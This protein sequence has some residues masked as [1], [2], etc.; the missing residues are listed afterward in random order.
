MAQRESGGFR[1]GSQVTSALADPEG[2]QAGGRGRVTSIDGEGRLT[3]QWEDNTISSHGPN[4]LGRPAAPAGAAEPARGV[5]FTAGGRTLTITGKH[6][7]TR[8]R[9][10]DENGRQVTMADDKVRAALRNGAPVGGAAARR[11]ERE[12]EQIEARFLRV[13]DI[14]ID[15][16]GEHEV[17]NI[18][19]DPRYSTMGVTMH[20]EEA[21]GEFVYR[22]DARLTVVKRS[23]S[24]ARG[25]PTIGEARE[26]SP[27]EPG[28]YTTATPEQLANPRIRAALRA[29]QRSRR[30]QYDQSDLESQLGPNGETLDALLRGAPLEI[31]QD[32]STPTGGYVTVRVPGYRTTD[33]ETAPVMY[34]VALGGNAAPVR[35]TTT[36][37][38]GQIPSGIRQQE[39]ER[40]LADEGGAAVAPAPVG[41]NEAD[42]QAQWD[43]QMARLRADFPGFDALDTAERDELMAQYGIGQDPSIRASNER[44]RAVAATDREAR[45][46]RAQAR[47]AEVT[48]RLRQTGN[49]TTAAELQQFAEAFEGIAE[50]DADEALLGR[51]YDGNLSGISPL[52]WQRIAA[53]LARRQPTPG[54]EDAYAAALARARSFGP[55]TAPAPAPAGR[56]AE[57]QGV[58]DALRAELERRGG[59][60]TPPVTPPPAGPTPPPAG[61][62]TP[63]PNAT[64]R[65]ARAPSGGLRNFRSMGVTKLRDTYDRVAWEGNDPEAL[66]ALKAEGRRRGMVLA[67][68]PQREPAAVPSRAAER[69]PTAPRPAGQTGRSGSGRLR[70][71]GAMS[72]AKLQQAATAILRELNDQEAIAAVDAELIRRGLPRPTQGG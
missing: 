58:T 5:T 13:D 25:R 57:Q 63:R 67:G 38:R 8:W 16:D 33:G 22:Q 40:L 2:R 51:M 10:R 9:L 4:D 48:T 64:T 19:I 65:T 37:G 54:N 69:G 61:G 41:G 35:E 68:V 12:T 31:V 29:A 42:P 52:T 46:A 39:W 66:A 11:P 18:D 26:V 55:A 49:G 59:G 71:F 23:D 34:D 1:V 14:V 30:G 62:A 32:A 6:T 47:A 56:A 24:G 21:G 53:E 3:V 60:A 28:L 43:A 7:P 70:N 27:R 20:G 72:D 36:P 17:T 50:G 15:E 44:K 45:V